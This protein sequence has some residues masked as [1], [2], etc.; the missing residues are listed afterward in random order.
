MPAKADVKGDRDNKAIPSIISHAARN[1]RGPF[2]LRFFLM[3]GSP[4]NGTFPVRSVD[5]LMIEMSC[6]IRQI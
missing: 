6:T 2:L 3:F 1:L 5:V 4:V